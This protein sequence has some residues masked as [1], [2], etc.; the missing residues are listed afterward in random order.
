MGI[1]EHQRKRPGSRGTHIKFVTKIDQGKVEEQWEIE[2]QAKK[3]WTSLKSMLLC[4][5]NNLS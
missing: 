5:R 1:W 2:K 4:V 3:I